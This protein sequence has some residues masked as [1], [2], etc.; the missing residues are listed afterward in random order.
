MTKRIRSHHDNSLFH[1]SENLDFI[2]KLVDAVGSPPD[3]FHRKFAL[4]PDIQGHYVYIETLVDK[5]KI[6][7]NVE[8]WI[9]DKTFTT[10]PTLLKTAP[11]CDRNP[12]AGR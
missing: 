6:E 11:G 1:E 4:S 3:L 12:F 7:D 9:E 10:F 5:S 8:E 2:H